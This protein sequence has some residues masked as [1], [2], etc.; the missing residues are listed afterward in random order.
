MAILRLERFEGKAVFMGK[1]IHLLKEE[2][3]RRLRSK[4]QIV[5]QDPYGAFNPRMTVRNIIDEGLRV[6][7]PHMQTR[8]GM[9]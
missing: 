1:E 3:M 7:Q 6:H 2:N 9:N 5:F 4:I 8:K